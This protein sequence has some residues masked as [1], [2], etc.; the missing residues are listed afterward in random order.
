M[1]FCKKCG[2]YNH[3]GQA[4]CTTCGADLK[5]AG[6]P[7]FSG[8][9]VK[10]SPAPQKP[11]VPQAPSIETATPSI[12]VNTS[13]L[14]TSAITIPAPV[15]APRDVDSIFKH[16]K[17]LLRQ[18]ALAIKE[19]Y[20][21]QDENG[22]PLMF[23]ERPA[24]LTQQLFMLA[25]VA[26]V[27]FGGTWAISAASEAQLQQLGPGLNSVAKFLE[28]LAVLASTAYVFVSRVPKR[29]VEFFTDDTKTHKVL[30]VKQ[31]NKVEFPFANFT[32]LDSSGNVIGRLRKNALFDYIRRRWYVMNGNGLHL[33]TAKEDSIILSFF[34]RTGIPIFD[35]MHTNFIFL[36]G[37]SI[38]GKF[39]RKFTIRDRYVL[40]MTADFQQSIDRR[41]A[42][43]T[44]VML[45]TGER[46]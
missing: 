5:S 39:N 28:F 24:L 1:I 17:L 33:C 4:T 18:K 38:V 22:N 14:T 8:G 35:F 12:T 9:N 43:A 26:A 40:D 30:E 2:R 34:R 6:H 25:A 36:R 32:I 44:G 7:S 21:V 29:H 45:D 19:K 11:A 37:P 15:S 13:I 3:D 31:L 10:I 16:D 20:Y 41:I 42:V 23:V 27:F 46:R